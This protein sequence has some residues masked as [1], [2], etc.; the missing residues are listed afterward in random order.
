MDTISIAIIF[1][2]LFVIV[3]AVVVFMYV[4]TSMGTK[5]DDDRKRLQD[6]I[7]RIDGWDND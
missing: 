4:V 6:I 7:D 5:Q 3:F 2:L 1:M